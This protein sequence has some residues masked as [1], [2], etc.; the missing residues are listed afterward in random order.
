MLRLRHHLFLALVV[1]PGA[2]DLYETLPNMPPLSFRRRLARR[3]LTL[4]ATEAAP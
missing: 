4:V 3:N 1:S 2:I